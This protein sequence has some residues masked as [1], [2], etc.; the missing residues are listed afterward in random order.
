MHPINLLCTIARVHTSGYYAWKRRAPKRQEKQE[1]DA[2]LA[3]LIRT[4]C[5][6]YLGKWGSR[7]VTMQ[8]SKSESPIN[9]KRIERVMR[10]YG[11]LSKRR[12]VNPYKNI[13][14]ENSEVEIAENILSRKYA[15]NTLW[16]LR[17][18]GTDIT[19]LRITGNKWA[20]FSAVKDFC[21]GEIVAYEIS[22]KPNTELVLA[23]LKIFATNV[24]LEYRLGGLMHSDRGSTYT[25]KAHCSV[26][27]GLGLNV[28]MSRKGNCI[29]NAPT[30]SFF[31]HMKDELPNTRNLTFE[32]LRDV[33]NEYIVDYNTV[34]KQWHREKMSPVD[35][36]KHLLCT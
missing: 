15:F 5:G 24:P 1:E 2:I 29:D 13:P 30:E 26:A 3:D 12:S 31:G 11:L 34:R 4:T 16:P 27:R 35:Y 7:Q 10:E 36:R 14:K 22:L 21:T 28:S 17:V 20:Y 18:F 25:S 9:H 8:I 6:K 23:T 33:V 19:F 32:E